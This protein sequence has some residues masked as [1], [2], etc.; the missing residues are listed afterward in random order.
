MPNSILYDTDEL[1]ENIDPYKININISIF[2][3]LGIWLS[4]ISV[5]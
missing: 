4:F 5:T 1:R 2:L 3:N